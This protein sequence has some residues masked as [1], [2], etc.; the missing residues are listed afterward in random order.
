MFQNVLTHARERQMAGNMVGPEGEY[1]SPEEATRIMRR[2]IEIDDR[3]RETVSV[4]SLR[5]I[6]AELDISEA[7]FRQAMVVEDL[8]TP[9][10]L[11][12]GHSR[13]GGWKLLLT[14]GVVVLGWTVTGNVAMWTMAA[15]LL[16][17]AYAW[18]AKRPDRLVKIVRGSAAL[19]S[20]V[21]ITAAIQS[22]AVKLPALVLQF[23]VSVALGALVSGL[24]DSHS[25]ERDMHLGDTGASRVRR[26]WQRAVDGFSRLFADDLAQRSSQV[27]IGYAWTRG[28]ATGT[29]IR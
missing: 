25:G 12:S 22:G 2:A 14:G 15:Q 8:G 5:S 27:L 1:K 9:V 6:A 19:W 17:M 29:N 13:F 20:G 28:A 24:R 4:E 3:L 18:N 16:F 7:A 21:M 10:V 23:V 26:M 11:P